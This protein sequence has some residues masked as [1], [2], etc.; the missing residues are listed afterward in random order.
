MYDTYELTK[1]LKRN[2]EKQPRMIIISSITIS[3]IHF[4]TMGFYLRISNDDLLADSRSSRK[5]T[6]LLLLWSKDALIELDELLRLCLLASF[7]STGVSPALLAKRLRISVSDTTPISRPLR[8]APG[9]EPVLMEAG[10]ERGNDEVGLE[11][12]KDGG[13]TAI[14]W[15][16]VGVGGALDAGLGEST[17]HILICK[18]I[19]EQYVYKERGW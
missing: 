7:G 15:G 3:F 12:V 11:L 10:P 1:H 6:E 8:F 4:I 14:A 9:I 5:S 16:I 17:T 2:E 19:R 18:Y 13:G